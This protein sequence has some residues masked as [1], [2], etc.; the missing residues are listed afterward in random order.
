M[1]QRLLIKNKIKELLLGKTIADQ[2]V[3]VRN[4]FLVSPDQF[5]L[6]LIYSDEETKEIFNVSPKTYK[7]KLMLSVELIIGRSK[8]KNI[9]DE[10]D[11]FE[12]EVENI[13]LFE[14]TLGDL[15]SDFY[16]TNSIKA[17]SNEAEGMFG[18]VKMEF[19]AEYHTDVIKFASQNLENVASEFDLPNL[20]DDTSKI[21]ITFEE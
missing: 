9:D 10:L 1:N 20:A 14:E 21:N 12:Q 6:I 18:M 17:F 2:N 16:I 3:I 19:V 15:V 8:D 7:R 4:P 11:Y 13:L 5:P